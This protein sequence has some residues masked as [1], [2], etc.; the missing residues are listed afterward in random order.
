MAAN[1][2]FDSD[3]FSFS[4]TPR[5]GGSHVQQSP[6]PGGGG[7]VGPPYPL[8]IP[9]QDYPSH[10]GSPASPAS[11]QHSHGDQHRS[12]HS[13]IDNQAYPPRR[14][15]LG[16]PIASPSSPL[17]DT[18]NY[19]QSSQYL[20]LSLSPINSY[21]NSPAIYGQSPMPSTGHVAGS[22]PFLS[23]DTL[24]EPTPQQGQGGKHVSYTSMDHL[25]YGAPTRNPNRSSLY[26]LSLAPRKRG[27]PYV[28]KFR[29]SKLPL[30]TYLLTLVQVIVFI[31]ELA[32]NGLFG[33][34]AI[35]IRC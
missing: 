1:D 30:V 15:S 3:R 13:P 25:A 29:N 16:Y 19:N 18:P 9:L 33:L 8:T 2:F 23:G 22:T 17:G 21:N 20:G 10:H 35:F 6:R 12:P 4:S 5:P 28:V 31:V 34:P 11:S 26:P 27:Q 24:A 14:S 7:A 32:R